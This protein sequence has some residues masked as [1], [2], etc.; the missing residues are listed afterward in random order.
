MSEKGEEVSPDGRR[1]VQMKMLEVLR[2]LAFQ[3]NTRLWRAVS[4][5]M[6]YIELGLSD[7]THFLCRCCPARVRACS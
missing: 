7:S 3:N 4:I 6:R 1:H 5:Q 2:S